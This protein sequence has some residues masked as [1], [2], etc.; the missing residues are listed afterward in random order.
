MKMD[1]WKFLKHCF[2]PMIS[3][4]VYGIDSFFWIVIVT[5]AFLTDDYSLQNSYFCINIFSASVTKTRFQPPFT[6]SAHRIFISGSSFYRSKGDKGCRSMKIYLFP[7]HQIISAVWRK[8]KEAGCSYSTQIADFL[9][10][11]NCKAIVIACN[12][13]TANALKEVQIGLQ[14]SCSGDWCY[15]PGAA[16]KVARRFTTM[17]GVI[18][19]TTYLGFIKNLYEKAQ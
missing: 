4:S 16:E 6:Q 9:L 1:I 7:G 5:T 3:R 8:S 11:K 15:Q 17:W 10:S 13:L 18:A 2:W 19:I 12:S 14:G